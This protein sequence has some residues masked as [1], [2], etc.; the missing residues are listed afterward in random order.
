M[1]KEEAYERLQHAIASCTEEGTERLA[2]VV[3]IDNIAD[4]VK[5]YGLNV[6]ADEVPQLLVD[7][8][9]EVYEKAVQAHAASRMLN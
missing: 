4:T 9:Q 8:A 6:D 7:V 2:V 5:V 1:T 3:L